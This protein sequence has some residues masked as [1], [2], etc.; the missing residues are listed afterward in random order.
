MGDR[1]ASPP[2]PPPD[3]KPRSFFNTGSTSPQHASIF[4]VAT[5][6]QT[7][8]LVRALTNESLPLPTDSGPVPNGSPIHPRLGDRPHLDPVIEEVLQR[9]RQEQQE[10]AQRTGFVNSS[11]RH[12]LTVQPISSHLYRKDAV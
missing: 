10:E 4:F 3:V 7:T 5:M 11:A 9:V 12:C 1:H 6:N 2:R 8:S